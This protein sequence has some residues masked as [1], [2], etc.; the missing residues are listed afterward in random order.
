MNKTLI[1]GAG[2]SMHLGFPSG[3]GLL[4][5]IPLD[6]SNSVFKKHF[7]Y[8]QLLS[9]GFEE[10]TLKD[11]W[12]AIKDFGGYSIDEL[13]ETREDL[14]SLG[15]MCIA[16]WILQY[17]NESR[18]HTNNLGWY[19][20]LFTYIKRNGFENIKDCGLNIVTFNYDRSIEYFLFN[21]IKSTY[22]KSDDEVY[23]AISGIKIIH[24][25]GTLGF[26]GNDILNESFNHYG[27][28]KDISKVLAISKNIK[29]IHEEVENNY[30]KAR[31]IIKNSDEIIVAGFG[32]SNR[33]T[34]RLEIGKSNAKKI[35]LGFYNMRE[36]DIETAI[37]TMNIAKNV[38]VLKIT[39]NQKALCSHIFENYL[40]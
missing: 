28:Y 37:S 1:L 25:H 16:K 30:I 33:N 35:I 8:N 15:K 29:V 38:E 19:R 13:L 40:D 24:L 34:D 7:E 11:L 36:V 26:M 3:K 27:D 4:R 32:Y 20:N 39:E 5:S 18:R 14:L 6:I 31:S 21:S 23:E 9:I 12:I 22:N 10:S 2:A 17:E